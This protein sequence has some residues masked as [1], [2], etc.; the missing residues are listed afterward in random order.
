MWKYMP[1]ATIPLAIPIFK[2]SGSLSF[3]HSVSG[4]KLPNCADCVC[5]DM[6]FRKCVISYQG[7]YN[8]VLDFTS[9]SLPYS[10]ICPRR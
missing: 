6:M 7:H 10:P 2:L 1:M 8:F 4:V 9:T 5:P 3:F